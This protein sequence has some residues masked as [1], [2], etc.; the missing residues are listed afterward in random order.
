MEW[1]GLWNTV[2]FKMNVIG[3]LELQWIMVE[4]WNFETWNCND[5]NGYGIRKN[6]NWIECMIMNVFNWF[7]RELNRYEKCNFWKL[8]H[9]HDLKG[10]KLTWFKVVLQNMKMIKNGF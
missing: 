10:E 9:E 8:V 3:K 6:L 2:V 4:N 5:L 1:H 7:K